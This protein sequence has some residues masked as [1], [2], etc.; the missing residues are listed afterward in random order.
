M[1]IPESISANGIVVNG[2]LQIHKIK[3]FKE[4]ISVYEKKNVEVIIKRKHSYRSLN[5]NSYFHSI[6]PF[7]KEAL[8]DTGNIMS[9]EEIKLMLKSMFL[10]EDI[11]NTDG[12]VIGAKIKGTSELNKM[13]FADFMAECNNWCFEYLG[14]EIP[15]PNENLQIKF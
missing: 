1:K 6:L 8:K 7:I 11:C 5:Q 3:E 10:K 14:C 13:Q 9:V 12:V 2:K 15:R 4:L